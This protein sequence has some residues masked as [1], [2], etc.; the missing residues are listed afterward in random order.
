MFSKST[1][2]LIELPNH[3]IELRFDRKNESVNKFDQRC[4]TELKEACHELTQNSAIKGLVVTSAK[5]TFVVGADITEFGELFSHPPEKIEQEFLTI[6]REVFNALEDLPFPT[7]AAINGIALG[8]GLEVALACDFRVLSESA[9]I[10]LPETSLGIIPGFG[11]TVR[12][13]RVIGPESAVS[14]ITTGLQNNASKA[15]AIG[16]VDAIESNDLLKPAIEFLENA[17]SGALAWRDVRAKKQSPYDLSASELNTLFDN[18]A[19]FVQTKFSG[20]YPAPMAAVNSMRK[21]ILLD[22]TEAIKVEARYFAQMAKTETSKQLINVFMGDQQVMKH[23]KNLAKTETKIEQAGVIGAGIMG[24]GIAYQSAYTGTPIVMKDIQQNGIDLGISEATNLLNGLETKGK[25]TADKKQHVL[26]KITP[27]LNYQKINAVDII[28]EAV[29]ENPKVKHAVLPEVESQVKE[30]AIVASNTSTISIDYLAQPLVRPEN[31]LGMHFFN[32]VHKMP[33]VEVIRGTKTSESTVAK[34]VGYALAMKKKPVVVKDCPGF[35]VNRVLFPYLGAFMQMVHEGVDFIQ[36]DKAMESF[37]WPMGPAH[38]CDVIGM[39]TTVHAANV[40]A[41]GFPDRM[42]YD[43]T[44]AAEHLLKN[45][46]LG[47]KNGHGFY[48]YEKDE[49][50]KVIKQHKQEIK[51]LLSSITESEQTVDEKTIA[52]RLMVVF[53]LEAVRCLEE[54]I[55]ERPVDLDMAMIYGL[56]FPQFRGGPIRYI[57]TLGISEFVALADKFSEFGNMYK[58]TDTLREMANDGSKHLYQ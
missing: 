58:V 50:G 55:V 11:G 25:I 37:G 6:N 3:F 54:N 36:I 35:L 29:V 4:L 10:G 18:A 43:F 41:D 20:H 26:D 47:Q 46:C 31:F 52:E 8:G 30:T 51:T 27:T 15:L 16:A 13:A 42:K 33:L 28:V 49:R 7:V 32:P 9:K 48:H 2:S 53:C 22:R 40:L 14:W 44:T 57:E 5:S 23:A 56:G 38:L 17:N 39:D 12:L 19:K 21:S 45:E 1:L 34:T 24:G